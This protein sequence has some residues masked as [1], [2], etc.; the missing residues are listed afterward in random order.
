[1]YT[2]GDLRSDI[3]QAEFE[4]AGIRPSTQ[5]E[6]IL[7][8]F[9]R[10]DTISA[11]C[12]RLLETGID[13]RPEL[14][15]LETLHGDLC[16]KDDITVRALGGQGRLAQLRA[17]FKPPESHWW[18]Y[19]DER[20]ARRR[21]KRLRR[22]AWGSLAGAIVVAILAALYVRFL[23]PDE[24]TRRR[25]DH[26]FSAESAIQR[27]EYAAALEAYKN[28]IEVAPDD[29]EATLMVGVMY[30]ALGGS[31]E[32]EEQ[33]ARAEAIY[34][35]RALLLA[36][37]AQQYNLLGWHERAAADSLAAIELDD[38]LAHPYCTLGSAY[39]GQQRMPEA[40]AAFQ[41]CADMARE[42]GHDE[43]YV[44]AITR[45]ATLMQMP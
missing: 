45:M 12:P 27:G 17:S 18:W 6:D 42:Q 10:L 34:G 7:A 5:A 31:S 39:E 8:L 37:R 23:R 4:V 40:I 13:L 28:A 3:R 29:A 43:L 44:I 21:A 16:D 2:V 9:Q 15:R 33:Y 32:A 11:A 41:T 20:I 24:A 22:L 25:L 19:L 30:E 38:S 26:V 35:S 1:V 36:A 14:S